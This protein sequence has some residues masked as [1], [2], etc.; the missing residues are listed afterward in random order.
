M[1]VPPRLPSHRSRIAKATIAAVFA[2]H[3]AVTSAQVA[4]TTERSAVRFD[5]FEFVVQGNTVLDV[6]T[7]ER[8][9]MPFMGPSRA[10]SDVEGARAAL[11]RAYQSR[12][13][14]SVGVDVPEQQVD[15]AVVVLQV[16]EATVGRL[17]VRGAKF[18]S[19]GVIAASVPSAS[20]GV[21][22]QFADVAADLAALNAGSGLVITPA[23]KPG[24]LPG[25]LDVD[26]DVRDRSP[27]TT[28]IDL[29]NQS[30]INTTPWR[31]GLGLKHSNF[32]ERRHVVGI[33]MLVTPADPSQ[34]KVFTASY[35]MPLGGPQDP[36]LSAYGVKS[37]SKT[38]TPIAGS[39]I[40]GGQTVVGL[41]MIT[42]LRGHGDLNHS[43]SVGAD[44]KKLDQQDFPRLTYLPFSLGY[45]AVRASGRQ[46]TQLETTLG[47]SFNGLVSED[48]SFA[49]RRYLGSASYAALR[50]DLTHEQPVSDSLSVRGRF[51]GQF[52]QQALVPAEQYALGGATSVRGYLES[53]V[54]G[55]R[56]LLAS[57]ELRARPV[58]LAPALTA[59]WLAFYDVGQS[60]IVDPRPEQ[61][62]TETLAGAGAG[63]RVRWSRNASVSIDLAR[64]LHPI[65][66][67][68][69]GWRAHVRLQLEL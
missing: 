67:Q 36:V 3:A 41:R 6:E 22:P 54:F 64:A 13:F 25:T 58:E 2:L 1:P 61:R 11:E 16:V 26:L 45:S 59:Q 12:G 24:R 8:A 55:D 60:A 50:W 66:T 46:Q 62:T 15:D 69:T 17:S 32:L 68:D 28:T 47:L 21:V 52:A 63:L 65:A 5:V 43:W 23:L 29:N 10:M 27:L 34:V 20:E 44:Y 31:L 42:P 9:V 53:S 48:D 38:P 51:A 56:A 49:A 37:D 57:L 4:E 40:L 30:A 18:Y 33:G 14:Q 7:I 39:T 19:P 35:A